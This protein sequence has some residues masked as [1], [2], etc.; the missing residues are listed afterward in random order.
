M[1]SVQPLIGQSIRRVE[2]AR[3][4]TGR[5]RYVDDLQ[6]PGTLS[7]AL[8][9]CPFPKAKILSID[10][11]AARQAPGVAK[12]ITGDD[13]AHLGDVFAMRVPGAQV[14][15]HPPLARD[16]VR[17]AGT[18]VVAVVADSP[19]RAAD[20]AT[21]VQVEYEPLDSIADPEAALQ[22]GAVRVWEHL[23]SNV[24]YTMKRES[25]DVDQAFA[26]AHKVVSLRVVSPRVA[27]IAMEPRGALAAPDAMGR[28]LTL[29]LATQS[30]HL[31]RTFI[32]AA[33]RYPENL[34]RVIA[35]DVGGGFGSKAG[36]YRED[37]LVAFLAL[38]LG[39]PVKWIATRNEDLMSTTQGRDMVMNASLAANSDG[40]LVALKV[41]AVANMGA[42]MHFATA[43]PPMYQ[44]TMVSGCYR[45][46]S[47]R[48]EIV[49]VFTTTTSTG[50]YR[51][52][53]RPEA[54]LIVERMVDQMARE[55]GL[56]QIEI[57]RKNFIQPDQFPYQ[58]A[59]G[60]VYDSGDYERALNRALELAGYDELVRE[61]DEA[62]ARGEL[63]G[64]GISTFVEPSGGAGFESGL[65]RVERTGQVTVVT[66][67]SSHGQGHETSFAQ[68][69][70]EKL[71]VPIEQVT[72]VHGDT[73]AT[74]V[75]VG[76][77]GSRS[78]ML[79]G[80]AVVRA[81]ERVVDKAKRIAANLL[82]AAPED[83]LVVEN[84]LGVVGAAEK[85]VTWAQLAEAAYTQLAKLP[86]G[87]E[88]GLE[89]TAY[90]DNKTEA[91]PFGTHIAVVRIDRETGQLHIQ[92]FVAVDDCGTIVNPMIVEG[93][94]LGGIAQG[95]GEALLEQV[96]F[97][98][99]GQTL[100]ASL[101]DYAV[102]RADTM[103]ELILDHT[104]TPSPLNPLGAKG[105]GEAGTNGCPPAIVNAV[106]DA[107]QPLG[108]QHLDKPFTAPLVWVAIHGK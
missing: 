91:W 20:A 18:P 4:V 82:E 27:A 48:S 60:A 103:P 68:V 78:M 9:R 95:I 33:L 16:V 100:T 58:S 40:T 1:E 105:V 74:P 85:K 55:L 77:F 10:L 106:A 73:A 54:V 90:F 59:T 38:E 23:D 7:M 97:D 75:G 46:P 61:R 3:L 56:D 72:V 92:K 49:G 19:A 11:S 29:W 12:I 51:G 87:E 88:P 99:S 104:E 76:T 107:L 93:Q 25:G 28:G 17:A 44:L 108:I 80:G 15:P 66:G 71:G 52:A 13:V 41:H 96:I 34:L 98:Q 102:P 24:C 37:I 14:P 26:T 39:A 21:L 81:T 67:A 22:E 64:I 36:V 65:V 84:G 69:A 101:M 57:R 86:E 8:V 70:A 47:I 6:L 50:P 2:D 89:A 35:P 79:G 63:M 31:S 43:L 42:Y 30:P 83:L 94:I 53:G 32:A 62:R 45:I 5:G